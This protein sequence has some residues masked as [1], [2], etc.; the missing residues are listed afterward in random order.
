MELAISNRIALVTGASSGIGYA[1]SLALAHEGVKVVVTGRREAVLRELARTIDAGSMHARGFPVAVDL[2]DHEAVSRIVR[3]VEGNVGH[4]DILVNCAGGS[5]PFES[6]VTSDDAWEE[7]MLLNFHRPRQ[8]AEALLG[9]MME[10]EWGRIINIT[11]KSEPTGVNGA[12]C[13]KAGVHS[14]AKGLS[15]MVGRSHVT[16]NCIAPGRIWSAQIR[17]NYSEAYINRQCDEEIP[18]GRYGDPEDVAHMVCFLASDMAG[19]VTGTV[20]PVDGGLRRYQF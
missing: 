10:R 11:G 17:R 3:Y 14:W 4:V 5:R 13:A 19:Y 8:L 18:L 15:R 9:G 12:F 6:L 7:A 2:T 20:I 1:I 16:V